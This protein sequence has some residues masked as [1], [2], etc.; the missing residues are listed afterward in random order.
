M[1]YLLAYNDIT[2]NWQLRREGSKLVM[3]SWV[4]KDDA[5]AHGVLHKAIGKQGG[6]VMIQFKDGSTDEVRRYPRKKVI[7]MKNGSMPIDVLCF[8]TTANGIVSTQPV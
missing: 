6:S 1:K 2:G 7:V 4:K 8:G 5:T 3:K